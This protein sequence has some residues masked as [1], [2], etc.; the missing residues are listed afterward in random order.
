MKHISKF[1]LIFPH[2]KRKGYATRGEERLLCDMMVFVESTKKEKDNRKLRCN[3][4]VNDDDYDDPVQYHLSLGLC[5]VFSCIKQTSDDRNAK[6]VHILVRRVAGVLF[7]C[8]SLFI[9]A[10]FPVVWLKFSHAAATVSLV[11]GCAP[12]LGRVGNYIF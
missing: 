12:A 4:A 1:D 11:Q 7:L 8:L 5:F 3:A 2:F 10:A 9:F 6:L